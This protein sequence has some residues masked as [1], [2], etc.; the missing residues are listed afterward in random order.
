VRVG[1]SASFE[2]S[3][4]RGT[5]RALVDGE[6]L[7][8]YRASVTITPEYETVIDD[9][10][11]M[12]RYR[13]ADNYY[14]I[15]QSAR[16]GY[17]R[18]EKREN[19]VFSTL[20]VNSIGYAVG[21]TTTYEVLAVGSD[22][23]VSIDGERVFA[24][25]DGTHASGSIALYTQDAV[26]FD[27]VAVVEPGTAPTIALRRPL[28]Q[29]V[30]P[31]SQLIVEAT[32]LN[33][34]AGSQVVIDVEGYAPRTFSEPPYVVNL[35]G[36]PPGEYGITARLLSAPG[37]NPLATHTVGEVA[38]G[39]AY[40]L[41][42]G[43]SNT[44]GL[45]DSYRTDNELVSRILGAQGYGG[46]LAAALDG[47]APFFNV[48]YNEGISGDTAEVT[49]Y[50]RLGS[51]LERHAP[52]VRALVAL[53]TNDISGRRDSGEDCGA[54]DEACLDDTIRGDLQA[55]VNELGDAGLE[56][57]TATVPPSWARLDGSPPSP[58]TSR[59]L[60][61]REVNRAI[62]N[63]ISGD[64][65]GPDLFE[66]FFTDSNNDDVPDVARRSLYSDRFH[67]NGLGHRIVAQLWYNALV[68]DA[69]GTAVSPFYLS[70]PTVAGYQQNL[71]EVGDE[72][73]I[74]NFET[75]ESFPAFLEDAIWIMP[76]QAD[77][78]AGGSDFLSFRA[79]RPTTLY[80][81]YDASA[82]GLPGWLNPATSAF[83][84]VPGDP[85]IR[86]SEGSYRLFRRN[87]AAGM[88]PVL[89]GNRA[90][91]GDAGLMYHPIVVDN[92]RN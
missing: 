43:D 7:T 36:V 48:V 38:V 10:G 92:S 39:G 25:S 16:H 1:Y 90:G 72:L 77:A 8:D 87:Y 68:G 19:G 71:I 32:T 21:Q 47:M 45:G 85:V 84:A 23:L 18:L 69:T 78:G 64:R 35:G 6:G 4:H 50:L 46:T 75:V 81:A 82:S 80:V 5:Y 86:T 62:R 11:F 57:W 63:G 60:L 27:N 88:S 20:G 70:E 2:E 51:L 91:N 40:V 15:S 29:A 89:G 74:D 66:F 13:D 24:V 37:G 67:F 54:G 9:I 31:G 61:T 65:D 33:A 42:V 28:N 53:G 58:T 22:L 17:T 44:N 14:R 12:F 30:I 52:A 49:R 34:P 73:K 56:V 26:R 3:Y 76:A 59:M 79:T 83:E 41:A 55:I